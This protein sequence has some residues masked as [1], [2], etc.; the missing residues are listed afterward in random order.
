[1]RLQRR[2]GHFSASEL[3]RKLSHALIKRQGNEALEVGPQHTFVGA[4]LA[5]VAETLI[6]RYGVPFRQNA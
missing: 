6:G 2:S 1:M 5:E 4:D 3:N